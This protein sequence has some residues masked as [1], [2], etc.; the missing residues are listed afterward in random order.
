MNFFKKLFGN[1]KKRVNKLYDVIKKAD[2]ELKEIRKECKHKTW[3]TGNYSYRIGNFQ[4]GGLCDVCDDWLGDA[5]SLKD[6]WEEFLRNW[7]SW[8]QYE[9]KKPELLSQKLDISFNDPFRQ[10]FYIRR[11]LNKELWELI[12]HRLMINNEEVMP[13]EMKEY[14]DKWIKG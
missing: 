2:D 9:L 1:P 3:H 10:R 7:Q 13:K 14:F 4:F 12:E 5:Q 11:E 6:W 8:A